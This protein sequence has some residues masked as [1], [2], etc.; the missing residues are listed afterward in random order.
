VAW[1][2]ERAGVGA[3]DSST[4]SPD[5]SSKSGVRPQ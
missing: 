4:G 2:L 5:Y 3:N 1:Y